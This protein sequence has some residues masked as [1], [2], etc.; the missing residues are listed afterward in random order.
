MAGC[1][2]QGRAQTADRNTSPVKGV[3]EASG[4]LLVIVAWQSGSTPSCILSTRK[5]IQKADVTNNI[6]LLATFDKIIQEKDDF[7]KLI[8][9]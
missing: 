3:R 5:R 4:K 2:P 1:R 7:L 8:Y 6:W 9:M